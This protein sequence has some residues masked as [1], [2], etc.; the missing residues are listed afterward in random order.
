MSLD[1][2]KLGKFGEDLAC[3]L[4]RDKGFEIIERNYCYKKG[5]IDIIAKDKEYLVFIE[6]KTRRNLEYGDPEYGVTKNKMKQI[7][8]IAAAY[9]YE[10]EINDV[11]IR[12]DVIAILAEGNNNPVINHIENAF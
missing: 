12:F 6:V 7:Q 4:V 3:K 1:S 5:E 9:L 10:K 8:K 2:D 11:D